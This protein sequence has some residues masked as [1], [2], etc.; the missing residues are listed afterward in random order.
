M[1]SIAER[2]DRSAS[3]YLR[4]WAPVLEPTAL[5]VLDIVGPVIDGHDPKHGL[6]S[7]R[8]N[9][10]VSSRTVDRDVRLLDIGTGTGALAVAVAERW[11]ALRVT[12]LDGSTGMLEVARAEARRRLGAAGALRVELVF[13]LA[14]RMPFADESFDVAVS[15]YVLQLV[16]HRLR[17]LREARRVLRPGGVLAF[18]TWLVADGR[19][20][21]DEAFY[22]VL[23]ELGIAEPDD[24]EEARSGDVTSPE[25]AAAQARRAGFRDVSARAKC[26]STATTR[27]RTSTSSSSTPNGRHSRG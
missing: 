8:T 19:F 3:A 17:A 21:P 16:P 24:T 15:S 25:A 5:G 18:V 20:A 6:A 27:R 7:G 11:P 13:G 1:S 9:D 26:S 2:Y 14:D 23:D 12:G 4:W 22:D 10:Q